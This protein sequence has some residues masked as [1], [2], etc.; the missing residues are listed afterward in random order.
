MLPGSSEITDTS[1]YI[2][3]E[4][5]FFDKSSTTNIELPFVS[6]GVKSPKLQ[7]VLAVVV[8][9][10]NFSAAF[11]PHKSL[12]SIKIEFDRL[13]F[14]DLSK[15]TKTGQLEDFRLQRDE[16]CCRIIVIRRTCLGKN[17][18]PNFR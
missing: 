7:P 3:S 6:V 1:M 12:D 15:G 18:H 17:L 4:S 10:F 2:T 16:F 11:A 9:D 5:M 8:T 14:S 13:S